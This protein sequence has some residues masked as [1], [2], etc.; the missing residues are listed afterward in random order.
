MHGSPETHCGNVPR[1]LDSPEKILPLAR[2][3][4]VRE[5]PP[6]LLVRV[7]NTH[8]FV[9]LDLHAVPQ[10]D[11]SRLARVLNAGSLDKL[12]NG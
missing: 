5:D 11:R 9:A 3:L 12:G 7:G 8:R 1:A 2:E 10:Q 6:Q 4:R